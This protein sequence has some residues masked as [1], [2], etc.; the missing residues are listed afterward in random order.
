MS[1]KERLQ[2]G[3]KYEDELLS[4][5]KERVK[6]DNDF[7]AGSFEGR[8]GYQSKICLLARDILQQQYQGVVPEVSGQFIENAVSSIF[9]LGVLERYLQD[10]RI[11]DIFIQ[12]TE[13]IIIKDGIKVFLGKVFEDIEEVMLLI[14]RIKLSSGKSVDQRMPFLNTD[15]YDG[16]R[17]SIIIPPVSDRI[18]IS[19]RVFNCRDFALEDL[20]RLGMF[21]PG[22]LD[23]LKDFVAKKKNIIISG[24]MGSGKTTLLSS[25]ARLIPENEIISLI[26][27][28]PEIKLAGH[29]YLRMLTTRPKTRETD[30]EINQE[31]LLFETLRMKADRIIVGEVR[32][33]TAAYQMLQALN[34]GH[35]GSFS[36]IHAD[37]AYDALLRI[38]MLAMEHGPNLSSGIVKK[39]VSRAIDIV[40]FLE[41]QKDGDNNIAAR[42]IKEIIEVGQTLDSRGDYSLSQLY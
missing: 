9:G 22:I 25:L 29:R 16:S 23:L 34:T 26:Q 3:T 39:I 8:Q 17:C 10:G 19:I 14:D 32:D 41:P 6:K 38:E 37:S 12:D 42:K 2:D 21:D 13:M 33:S 28:L 40:I 1:L 27:D 20:M 15:L 36:T 31:R 30:F 7:F 24:S 18:Y 35:R 4:A 5:L 11:T